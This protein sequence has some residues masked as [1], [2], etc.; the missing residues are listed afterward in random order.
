LLADCFLRQFSQELDKEIKGFTPEAE[1]IL[2]SQEW[3]G[4]IRELKNC[5]ERQ[6]IYCRDDWITSEALGINKTGSMKKIPDEMFVPLEQMQL[7]YIKKVLASTVN[8]KTEAARFLGISR[9]TLRE[10]LR[11]GQLSTT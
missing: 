5:I 4:N 2:L 1:K 8:N 9:T 3:L 11:N 6:V 10:K 7:R